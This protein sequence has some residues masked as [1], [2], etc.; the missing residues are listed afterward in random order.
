[1]LRSK[2]KFREICLRNA[3]IACML[4]KLGAKAGLTIFNITYLIYNYVV[5]SYIERM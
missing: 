2:L 5:R 4:L 3:R 1:M